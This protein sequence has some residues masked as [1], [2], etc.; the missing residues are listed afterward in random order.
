M[1]KAKH[2]TPIRCF[3][4]LWALL[5]FGRGQAQEPPAP[6]SAIE[7][8]HFDS[9]AAT[10]QPAV[11]RSIPDTAVDRLRR[12]DA[13][14]YA[15]S[16]PERKKAPEPDN[17]SGILAARW[18]R[19]LMWVIIVTAFIAVVIW[20][21][22]ASNISLFR[23]PSAPIELEEEVLLKEDIFSISYDLE[24][25]RAIAAANHRLAIR[26]YYLSTLKELADRELIAYKQDKTNS[27]YLHELSGTRYYTS[28][29]RLTRDFEYSWY[30][31]FPISPAAFRQ[32]QNEFADF[33]Q[34]LRS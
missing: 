26:L 2:D 9:L 14:W 7:T 22:A 1:L 29:F 8:H 32:V 4:L 19:S 18:F 27:N 5:A 24:I 33:K 31:G 28:F 30:G 25:S 21:L 6:D 15:N 3:F 13:Y 12:S 16:I 10:Q 20:Y 23:R 11:V 17:R 34:L